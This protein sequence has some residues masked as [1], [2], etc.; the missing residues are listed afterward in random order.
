[1][2]RKVSY[3]H[4][5]GVE[6]KCLVSAQQREPYVKAENPATLTK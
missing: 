5:I 4:G 2:F 6:W 3:I 1:M